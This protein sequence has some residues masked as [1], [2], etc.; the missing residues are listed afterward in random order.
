[1]NG[2]LI[3]AA[4]TAVGA[5]VGS[6]ATLVAQH[7]ARRHEDA[8]RFTMDRRHAYERLVSASNK[9]L[10]A[11]DEESPAEPW[12]DQ[13]QPAA[14]FESLHGGVLSLTFIA[15]KPVEKAGRKLLGALKVFVNASP[16]GSKQ[17]RLDA[18]EARDTFVA[19]A[20]KELRIE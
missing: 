18:L 4:G 19:L 16:E 12:Q 9:I 10:M 14:I 1:M 13:L 6:A 5:V 8:H 17:A 2:E 20:R 7:L 15:S 11:T 3:A